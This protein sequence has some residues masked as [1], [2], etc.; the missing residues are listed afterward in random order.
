MTGA[1]GSKAHSRYEDWKMPETSRYV[2]VLES[3]TKRA[4]GDDGSPRMDRYEYAEG[5]V[6][7]L[8]GNP[9][10]RFWYGGAVGVV[11]FAVSWFPTSWLVSAITIRTIN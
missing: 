5:V 3:F 2:A 11:K 10:P 4:K 7:R 6:G 9:G 1:V 8:L